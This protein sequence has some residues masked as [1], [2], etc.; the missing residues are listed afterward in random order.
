MYGIVAVDWEKSDV[1]FQLNV[2]IPCNMTATVVFP[3]L[4]DCPIEYD[5]NGQSGKMAENEGM[6]INIGSGSYRFHM[7]KKA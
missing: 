3:V 5:L 6:H 2:S 1:D 4:W 7:A